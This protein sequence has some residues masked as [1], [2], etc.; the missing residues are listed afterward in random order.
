MASELMI[1]SPR[2]F[3]DQA[4]R[5]I[6]GAMAYPPLN[7]FETK[8]DIVLELAV[9]GLSEKEIRIEASGEEVTLSGER[10]MEEANRTD[11]YLRHE[12]S[13]QSF[14]RVIEL[15]VA[16]QCGEARAELKHGVLRVT[17]PKVKSAQPTEIAISVA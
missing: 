13:V 7:M 8:T 5:W 3:E 11:N 15:P 12:F 1:W 6:S 16:V 14:K 9:P 17:L 10:S 4:D 2:L